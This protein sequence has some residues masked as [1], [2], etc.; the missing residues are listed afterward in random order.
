RAVAELAGEA[1]AGEGAF[2]FANEFFLLAGGNASFGC[3]EA[4]VADA[5]GSLGVLFEILVEVLAEQA[6]H[7]ALDFAVAE[8]GLGLAFELRMRNAT[9][10]DCGEAF[11]EIF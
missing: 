7:D 10:D 4:F 6:V 2:A 5:L 1:A 8:L 11:A 3:K 9:A